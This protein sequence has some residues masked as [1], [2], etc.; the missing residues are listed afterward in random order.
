MKR[1]AILLALVAGG[2]DRGYG[3]GVV[4]ERGCLVDPVRLDIA[5]EVRPS[6]AKETRSIP[7]AARFFAESRRVVILP[8]EGTRTVLVDVI[9]TGAGGTMARGSTQTDVDG[10]RVAELMIVLA[11]CALSDGGADGRA[12]ADASAD[13]NLDANPDG[14][15]TDL[16][17][18]V[19]AATDG[20]RPDLAVPCT[21]TSCKPPAAVCDKATGQCVACLA[22]AHCPDGALCKNKACVPGCGPGRGCGDAGTCDVDAGACR[23]CKNNMD[24]P[25]GRFCDPQTGVCAPCLVDADCK[26]G[27]CRRVGGMLQ[28]DT[29]CTKTAECSG[30][31]G[32]APACCSG[33]CVDTN[34]DP[35]N[36]MSCGNGCTI[37]NGSAGCSADGCV[38]R[39]C[40]APFADCN[41]AYPDGCETNTS[42]DKANCL[43][44]GKK[45]LVANGADACNQ[46]CLV[47]SCTMPFA[48]C[49]RSFADGCETDTTTSVDHCGGCDAPCAAPNNAT[50]G[51]AAGKCGIGACKGAFRDCNAKANDGCEIDSSN[52]LMNCG[53]CGTKCPSVANGTAACAGSKCGVGSCN[54]PWKD[55]N[56]VAGDGC[57]A[58]TSSDA[59]HCGVCGKKCGG[60]TPICRNGQCEAPTC[61]DPFRDCNGNVNDGCET[62]T[63]KDV[64]HCGKCANAC[65]AITN[66]TPGCKAGVCGVGTCNTPWKDCNN[67][68]ADGCETNTS[69]SVGNCNACGNMCPPITNGVAACTMSMCGLGSCNAPFANCD[70]N[71]GNGC[72][73]DTSRDVNHCSGCTKKCNPP[74]N[75]T[76][77]CAMSMCGV[78]TCTPPFGDCDKLPGNGC[79]IDTSGNVDHCSG[80]GKA[81]G[82]VAN[83]TAGCK[84]SMCVVVECKAPFDDCDG[85]FANGCESDTSSDLANCGGCGNRCTV[86]NGTPL[87]K[88][89]ECRILSCNQGFADCNLVYADGCESNLANDSF[90]CGM[91]GRMCNK[92]EQCVGGNCQLGPGGID[93]GFG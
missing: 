86:A 1:V 14:S 20:A 67:N 23:F 9:A 53:S 17:I 30:P 45:C 5:V 25:G 56:G 7:D 82:A 4:I 15:D 32:G 58:D 21:E 65:P 28:C 63:S 50:A 27:F 34:A 61:N 54:A 92:L 84:G 73:T 87:C 77:A 29:K 42:K 22:D 83:G 47:E 33:V 76:A 91:C 62:D 90:N 36:C 72:E 74:P 8:P 24:C 69:N 60:A 31:D 10:H 44:C 85:K 49:N 79:E 66:G 70:N 3:V 51:C 75:A 48:D 12:S 16:A 52:D 68:P 80:C 71:V 38:V 18:S 2:C 40:N 78:G 39:A 6:G 55:C 35:A 81:C 19:D 93:G 57:E 88:G 89:A 64:A 46:G 43:G 11:G 59:N 41:K 37:P 26:G 13:A